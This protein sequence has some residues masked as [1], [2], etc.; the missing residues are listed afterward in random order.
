MKNVFR[1]RHQDQPSFEVCIAL[2]EQLESDIPFLEFGTAEVRVNGVEGVILYTVLLQDQLD[3]MVYIR[4]KFVT[5]NHCPY[6]SNR[7][8]LL[9]LSKKR[10][11]LSPT[12]LKHLNGRNRVMIIDELL[13][14]GPHD[15]A[16][17]HEA[18]LSEF[19]AM[20]CATMLVIQLD[21]HR[22]MQNVSNA[23]LPNPDMMADNAGYKNTGLFWISKR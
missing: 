13:L 20:H 8:A 18:V 2:N 4:E 1:M 23:I 21:W 11:V 22:M 17:A 12:L 5:D 6:L 10:A 3:E 14:H 9:D 19:S 15:S 7:P 16:E